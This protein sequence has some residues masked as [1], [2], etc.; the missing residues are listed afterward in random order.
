[1]YIPVYILKKVLVTFL[2]RLRLTFKDIHSNNLSIVS[3]TLEKF[4]EIHKK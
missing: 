4:Q 3:N 1:M 2:I